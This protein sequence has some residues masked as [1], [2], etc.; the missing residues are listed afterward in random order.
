MIKEYPD[1]VPSNLTPI[2]GPDLSLLERK[3][4]CVLR[5]DLHKSHYDVSENQATAPVVRCTSAAT[6][7]AICALRLRHMGK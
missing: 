3:G 4:R 5:G 1:S 7:D 6:G 2:S